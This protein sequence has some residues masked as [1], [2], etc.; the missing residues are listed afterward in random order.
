MIANVTVEGLSQTIQTL[1]NE[2][3]LR[4]QKLQDLGTSLVE[5]WNLMDTS[6]EERERCRNVVCDLG[7]L[8][9]EVTSAGSLALDIIDEAE[10]EVER[11]NLLKASK[12]KKLVLKK[13]IRL[14]EI[15]R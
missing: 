9:T 14:E 12:M 1:K 6:K 11:L 4:I 5:L 7:A 10:V 8:D 2:K 13:W 3:K 15:C